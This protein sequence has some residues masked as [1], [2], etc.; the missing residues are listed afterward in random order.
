MPEAEETTSRHLQRENAA[1]QDN[2]VNQISVCPTT[3]LCWALNHW[4]TT[5]K[6][7]C[8]KELSG[9]CLSIEVNRK[10]IP[11]TPMTDSSSSFQRSISK[12][13]Q[14]AKGRTKNTGLPLRLSL[15]TCQQT[16]PS[17][18]R[19]LWPVVIAE[20]ALPDRKLSYP[21]DPMY[22]MRPFPHSKK[23]STTAEQKRGMNHETVTERKRTTRLRQLRRRNLGPILPKV[24]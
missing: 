16:R 2:I 12:K 1:S 23:E 21:W 10:K 3:L 6:T 24:F 18:K 8:S 7:G 13:T 9:H 20:A 15:T 22:T 17:G 5:A 14:K 4:A 19:S 11:S